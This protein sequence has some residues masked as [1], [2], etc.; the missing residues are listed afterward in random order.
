M[1]YVFLGTITSDKLRERLLS[2]GARR[3][4][5][6]LVQRYILDGL[7]SLVDDIF[8]IGSP[9]I[10]SWPRCKVK[11][12]FG[13]KYCLNGV[14]AKTVGF[15]NVFFLNYLSRLQRFKNECRK[16]ARENKNTPTTII[17]YSLNST[18]LEAALIM[19]RI[20]KC[21]SICA[22]VPD[23]PQFMS[24]YKWPYSK[25]KKMNIAKIEK[26]RKAV[27][28]YVLYSKQ[29][30]DFLHL[31]KT[32]FIVIEGFIDEKKV[33]TKR[34]TH[35]N[36]KKICLYAGDLSP[37]YGI[38]NMI[39]AFQNIKI[40]AELHIYGSE[41]MISK[42]HL[43]QK[44]KYM[45]KLSPDDIFEKMKNSD[46]LINPRPSTLKLTEFS[47]P[48]KTFEYMASGTPC[49]MCRLPSL[50]N[51]F[52]QH[53]FF[54]EEENADCFSKTITSILSKGNEELSEKGNNAAIFIKQNYSA[55]VQVLKIINL[56]HGRLI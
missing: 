48:S 8:V 34:K 2:L 46:L 20:I 44:T 38:Q 43:N 26:L 15:C 42:Y 51:S 41:K 21:A 14:S 54:F 56:I 29:M 32:Q 53:L 50:P 39:D 45:G 33:N 30:A 6:D 12:V 13:E 5:G 23:L 36:A 19:K 3:E 7:S 35:F 17:V 27:D 1:R 28:F 25:F 31:Q 40:D 18:F 37:V 11:A 24:N 47:F 10:Q 55:S 4:P 22:I 49:V 52:A 16:W 9:R